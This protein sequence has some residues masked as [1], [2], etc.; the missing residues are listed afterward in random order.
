MP[1]RVPSSLAIATHRST[2]PARGFG[3][4]SLFQNNDRRRDL[5]SV[6]ARLGPR[7][8]Q[9]HEGAQR[10]LCSLGN[11]PEI[12]RPFAAV[13]VKLWEIIW[14]LAPNRVFSKYR[15]IMRALA[16]IG[17]V[18]A[19]RARFVGRRL[20]HKERTASP[21]QLVAYLGHGLPED[22]SPEESRN[23]RNARHCDAI[24]GGVDKKDIRRA[25]ELMERRSNI[26]KIVG[27][28]FVVGG[29]NIKDRRLHLVH[30]L[31]NINDLHEPLSPDGMKQHRSHEPIIW[32]L[33]HEAR[34]DR[35]CI[36][37]K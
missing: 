14:R 35:G 5:I 22:M 10:T 29:M 26:A 4:V 31:S 3:C 6:N 23:P 21:I 27:E 37:A 2:S 1:S 33:A 11:R 28:P 30:P 15:L 34:I 8:L 17:V 7:I 16:R 32:T 25:G 36:C 9:A 12:R 13:P 20:L 24:V 18:Q 19:H